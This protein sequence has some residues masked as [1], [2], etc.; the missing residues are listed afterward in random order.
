M[1]TRSAPTATVSPKNAVI[2]MAVSDIRYLSK[3]G[4]NVPKRG[5]YWPH[6]NVMVTRRSNPVTGGAVLLNVSIGVTAAVGC[7]VSWPTDKGTLLVS[8]QMFYII[9][10]FIR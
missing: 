6:G 5:L 8:K 2:N 10:S 4:V 1:E 9:P 7:V 3:C